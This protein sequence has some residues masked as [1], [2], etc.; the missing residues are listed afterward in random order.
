[1]PN[2]KVKPNS[3]AE[4][5]GLKNGDNLL[6]LNNHIIKDFIDFQYFSNEEFLELEIVDS[7]NK[8]RK[9]NIPR[10]YGEELGI[11]IPF[12]SKEVKKCKNNCIF[13][14]IKQ[15]PIN[16]RRSLRI[17]DDDYR[18]SFL[19]GNYITL[20]NLT[21]E[22]WKRIYNYFL[23][24]LYISVHTTNPEIR[25]KMLRNKKAGNIF[26][27]LKNLAKHRIQFHVQIVLCQGINDGKY[28]IQ[29]LLDLDKLGS[30]VLSIAI[31]PVGLTKYR[32]NLP[33]LRSITKD[34]AR[35]TIK[36]IYEWQNYFLRK[37]NN[38]LVYLSDEFYYLANM[39]FPKRSYY[40]NFCQLENGV[41]ISRLFIDEFNKLESTLPDSLK[42]NLD[43]I[44][45][46]GKIAEPT[47]KPIVKRLN[48]IK[49]L[50]VELLSIKNKFWGENINV[51]G[52]ITGYDIIDTLEQVSGLFKKQIWIPEVMVRKKGDIFLDNISI[53]E[54]EKRFGTK[55]KVIPETAKSLIKEIIKVG[56]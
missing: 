47:L 27:Y 26:T 18:L 19:H 31:V 21:Q 10:E 42:K 52:L 3:I 12:D 44:I 1:M 41:G 30:S 9:I 54:I 39:E 35:F 24:P 6:K 46:S 11:D 34:N 13:C 55:I 37:Y 32:Q 15:Q 22:D 50:N 2:I 20:T 14:F 7:N 36:E 29:T 48:K 53:K 28:L 8:K 56:E 33:Y 5:Y 38:P 45:I 43:I 4:K 25:F 51:T 17:Y 49:N 23:T 40:G 16:L